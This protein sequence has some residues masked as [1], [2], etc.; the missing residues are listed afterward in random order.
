M[1]VATPITEQLSA[2]CSKHHIDVT[3]DV[4]DSLNVFANGDSEISLIQKAK[5]KKTEE[6]NDV[7]EKLEESSQSDSMLTDDGDTETSSIG[8]NKGST[9][10]TP[11]EIKVDEQVIEK[12]VKKKYYWYGNHK[13]VKPIKDIPPRFQQMLAETKAEK[14]RCEGRPIILQQQVEQNRNDANITSTSFNPDA[15]CFIPNQIFDKMDANV[16]DMPLSVT[17]GV[18]NN[19]SS[20]SS[21]SCSSNSSNTSNSMMCSRSGCGNA[22]SGTHSEML[23]PANGAHVPFTANPIY[24]I[25]IYS[26]ANT[27]MTNASI[28]SSANPCCMHAT[29]SCTNMYPSANNQQPLQPPVYYTSQPFSQPTYATAEYQPF[30]HSVN[31]AQSVQYAPCITYTQNHQYPLAAMPH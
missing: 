20:D 6:K 14:I 18:S 11:D 31:H 13:L 24:T 15:Q 25:H 17:N 4:D 30:R 5:I 21:S 23:S 22:V 12:K 26:S 1:M 16:K 2:K 8:S 7:S 28:S 19:S 27:P 10:L 29:N 3:S 9:G